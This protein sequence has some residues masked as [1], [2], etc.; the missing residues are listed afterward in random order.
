MSNIVVDSTGDDTSITA[1]GGETS[2]GSSTTAGLFEAVIDVT[3]LANG[4]VLEITIYDKVLSGST[5]K[6]VFHAV[7]AHAQ[8]EKI[9]ISP[10]HMVTHYFEAALTLTG[11]TRTFDWEFRRA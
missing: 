4:D 7:Y 3:N 10:P 8:A 9:K 11:T 6:V 2:L 1:G 5:K